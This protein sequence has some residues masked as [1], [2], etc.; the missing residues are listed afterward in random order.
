MNTITINGQEFSEDDIKQALYMANELIEANQT[1][2]AQLIAM[3]A[4]L[5]NEEKKV[6]RLVGELYLLQQHKNNYTA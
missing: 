3:N 2:N 6:K 1:L 5:E 4:K